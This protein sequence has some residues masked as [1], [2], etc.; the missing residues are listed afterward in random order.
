MLDMS[1]L[2]ILA[3]LVTGILVNLCA[4]VLAVAAASADTPDSGPPARG[5]FRF[6]ACAACGRPRA[7]LA[8]SGL[9]AYA[10]GRRRCPGCSRPLS[11]RHLLVEVATIA[12][13]FL[14]WQPLGAPTQASTAISNILLAAYGAILLLTLVT[15]L[16]FRLV[17]HVLMLP[18]IALAVVAAFVNP[19]WNSPASPLLGGALGLLCGL[20]MYGGGLLF[21]RLLGRI[22]GQPIA[23]TA[24]GFGDVTLLTFIGLIVGVPAILLA[25]MIGILCGGLFSL[26]FL[27]VRGLVHNEYALFTAIPYAPFLILGGAVMLAFGQEILTW[28]LRGM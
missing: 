23:E 3:G 15:D 13:F 1:A 26:L 14:V 10:T 17:P 22:R 25:L 5:G 8:W 7:L 20:I 16:E 6:P 18:A 11:L 21:V 24:F 28:Y 2:V 19:A 27:V 4:D 9:L 12:L